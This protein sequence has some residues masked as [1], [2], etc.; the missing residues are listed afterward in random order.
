MCLSSNRCGTVDLL[1]FKIYCYSICLEK[2]KPQISTLLIIYQQHL[3]SF[4]QQL[5]GMMMCNVVRNSLYKH[6][7]ILDMVRGRNTAGYFSC[8]E[9]SID[10]SVVKFKGKLYFKRNLPLANLEVIANKSVVLI[11]SFITVL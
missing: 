3:G 1:S 10:K 11:S 9:L 6:R 5:L 8:R 2:F 4:S 7:P